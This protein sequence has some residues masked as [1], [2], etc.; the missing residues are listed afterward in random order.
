MPSPRVIK[1][2]YPFELLP[3]G[4]VDTCRV[5]FVCR[6]VKDVVVSYFHHESLLKTHGLAC[7][8][9]HYARNIFRTS[10]CTNGGYFEML[11]SGWKRRGNTN[12]LFLWYEEMKENQAQAIQKIAGHV[13]VSLTPEA[14]EKI[15]AFA[16]FENYKKKSTVNKPIPMWNEGKGEFVRKGQVGD[17]VNMFSPE[18]T[19]EYDS[20]IREEL[21]RLDITDPQIVGYFKLQGQMF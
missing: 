1:T 10:L 6:N 11:E 16:K 8:F 5:I 18:L 13:G 2:H 14:L 3:E 12:L 7:G 21:A 19:S 15:D 17:W 9:E 20:W 4:L